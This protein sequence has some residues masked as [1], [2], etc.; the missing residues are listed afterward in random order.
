MQ[1]LL[2]PAG[3]F[4]IQVLI[5]SGLLAAPVLCSHLLDHPGA[6]KSQ[7]AFLAFSMTITARSTGLVGSCQL[8]LALH[9]T[10]SLKVFDIVWQSRALE[11]FSDWLR[12]DCALGLSEGTG[13]LAPRRW[14]CILKIQ[15]EVRKGKS[16]QHI[17]GCAKQWKHAVD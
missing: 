14:P 9:Q 10:K 6:T 17:A 7:G 5:F 4:L 2:P 3:T 15:E 12:S 1:S 13:E 11:L 8:R 16:W